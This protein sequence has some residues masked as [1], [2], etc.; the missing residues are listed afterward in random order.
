MRDTMTIREAIKLFPDLL[1][2][3]VTFGSKARVG[4]C[5]RRDWSPSSLS[6]MVGIV[7][8]R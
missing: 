1:D 2:E 5:V 8:I 4:R 6:V 3:P 7:P